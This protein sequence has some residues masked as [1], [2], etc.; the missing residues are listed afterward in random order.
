MARPSCRRTACRTLLLAGLLVAPSA[1]AHAHAFLDHAEPPVGASLSQSPA[2]L[3]LAFTEPVEP[4]FSRIEVTDGTG[5]HI[6]IG[7]VA[8]RAPAILSVTLPPLDPGRY[9]VTWSVVSLDHHNTEGRFTLT[10]VNP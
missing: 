2:V 4:S 6:D 7:E 9:T 8:N 10:V 1:V 3:R 5:R